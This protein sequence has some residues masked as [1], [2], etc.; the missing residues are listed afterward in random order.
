MDVLMPEEQ[1]RVNAISSAQILCLIKKL[2]LENMS[3]N[4]GT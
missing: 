3:N 1:N 4:A 2:P